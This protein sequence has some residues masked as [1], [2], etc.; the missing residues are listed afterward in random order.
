[1]YNIWIKLQKIFFRNFI[2]VLL[3]FFPNFIQIRYRLN[4]DKIEIKL[5]KW[6]WTAL[7]P[8][9]TIPFYPTPPRTPRIR[10]PRDKVSV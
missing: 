9:Y 1:M 2:K 7:K 4:L 3:G 8:S 5:D 10:I 6:T